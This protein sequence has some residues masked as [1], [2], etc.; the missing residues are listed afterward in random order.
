MI[1]DNCLL[2]HGPIVP[3]NSDCPELPTDCELMGW[4]G[5]A[6]AALAAVGNW[7]TTR[8]VG[9]CHKIVEICEDR[10]PDLICLALEFGAIL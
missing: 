4:L 10:R 6:K 7:S 8:L 1:N 3:F 5:E 2:G 9:E